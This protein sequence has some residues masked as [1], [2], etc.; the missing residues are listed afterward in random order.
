[1]NIF[2]FFFFL[3]SHVENRPSRATDDVAGVRARR[4]IL[5]RRAS[6]YIRITV[7]VHR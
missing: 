2:C 5:R 3:F 1:M 7:S 4:I 6:A